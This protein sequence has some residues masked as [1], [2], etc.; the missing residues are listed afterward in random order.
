M[1]D[2]LIRRALGSEGHP[3]PTPGLLQRAVAD[4][5]AR[6][7]RRRAG[8]AAA[9]ALA[10]VGA[11]AIVATR[12]GNEEIVGVSPTSGVSTLPNTTT[13][14]STP[15]LTT[16]PAVASTSP[17]S[18]STSSSTSAP[19]SP[20]TL[21][22]GT[23]PPFVEPPA[24]LPCDPGPELTA[25]RV[26]SSVDG[27]LPQRRDAVIVQRQADLLTSIELWGP[28]GR[29][30]TLSD[31]VPDDPD[32]WYCP[33]GL[34]PMGYDGRFL[35][36]SV[37]SSAGCS[38]CDPTPLRSRLFR[39]D[40]T[41]GEVTEAWSSSGSDQV[42]AASPATDGSVS[43]LTGPRFGVAGDLVFRPSST[44]S[45]IGERT[46]A[47]DGPLVDARLFV[48]GTDPGAPPVV[49]YIT[50]G[51]FLPPASLHVVVLGASEQDVE[52]DMTGLML[53]PGIIGVSPDGTGVLVQERWEGIGAVYLVRT[54]GGSPEYVGS[55]ACWT[56]TGAI[57][58][59]TWTY[60]SE[61]VYEQPGTIEL[62]EPVGLSVVADLR[63]D[64]YGGALA[65]LGGERVAVSAFEAVPADVASGSA[66]SVVPGSERLL[67]VDP[68]GV[69]ELANDPALRVVGRNA[70]D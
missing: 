57:A 60:D 4:G 53:D 13:V 25:E 35:W 11:G 58:R 5:T 39:A 32:R 29:A 30:A 24:R 65:C 21:P 62:V 9:A 54:G 14:A 41:T 20:S 34:R 3:D 28:D 69:T 42:L 18:S 66:S 8:V 47:L 36:S 49:V 23:S 16:A 50:G 15:P 64:S 7:R 46:W 40:L 59:S 37:D 48:A 45:W 26:S 2:D 44:D 6:R 10:V 22:V 31:D 63:L 52:V 27:P 1:D 38:M 61:V 56:S 19:S 33:T 70:N 67:L 43:V 12:G 51:R 68:G 55:G 17:S